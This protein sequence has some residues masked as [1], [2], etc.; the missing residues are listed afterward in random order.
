MSDARSPSSSEAAS[1]QI[2]TPDR[3]YERPPRSF[4]AD[5]IGETNLLEARCL[6]SMAGAVPA[7]VAA[8]WSRFGRM[9]GAL[10]PAP[11]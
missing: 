1:C 3:V 11:T 8:R 10:V 2:G 5:F 6:A 9:P 7:P 4:V